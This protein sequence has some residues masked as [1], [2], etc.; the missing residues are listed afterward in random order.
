MLT[1]GPSKHATFTMPTF[2]SLWFGW[3]MYNLAEPQDIWIDEIAVDYKPIGCPSNG[4][5][6]PPSAGERHACDLRSIKWQQQ[7]RHLE[8]ALV[9]AKSPEDLWPNSSWQATSLPLPVAG[10]GRG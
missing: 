10:E 1:S 2:N 3:W 8:S 5:L 9:G 6:D 7:A 4:Y